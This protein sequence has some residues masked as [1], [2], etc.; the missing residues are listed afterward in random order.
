[1]SDARYLVRASLDNGRTWEVIGVD[2]NQPSVDLTATRFSGQ[3]VRFEIVASTGLHSRTLE[4]GPVFVPE[5]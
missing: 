3:R 5:K 2:L 4:F 1:V